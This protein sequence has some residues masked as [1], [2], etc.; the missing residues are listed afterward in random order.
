MFTTLISFGSLFVQ[1]LFQIL[2]VSID[3]EWYNNSQDIRDI[4]RMIGIINF[5]GTDVKV[6]EIVFSLSSDFSI[7][8]VGVVLI[9]LLSIHIIKTKKFIPKYLRKLFKIKENIINL[10]KDERVKKPEVS[11][12]NIHL[13]YIGIV[14][15]GKIIFSYSM[16]K[17]FFVEFDIFVNFYIYYSGM[18]DI[19]GD[20][21]TRI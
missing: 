16:F 4:L 18:D 14:L 13:I 19:K 1:I 10:E 17:S 15:V 21:C 2:F 11:Y 12:L 6:Y 9:A 7:F 3:I 5:S 20:M 8:V